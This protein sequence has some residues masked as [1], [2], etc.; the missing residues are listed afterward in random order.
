MTRLIPSVEPL[1]RLVGCGLSHTLDDGEI[2]R[3]MTGASASGDHHRE[4]CRFA[5]R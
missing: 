3:L 4:E 2:E 1:V 5:R